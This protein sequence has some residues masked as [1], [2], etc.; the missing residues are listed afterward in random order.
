MPTAT[1]SILP[2]SYRWSPSTLVNDSTIANPTALIPT[3]TTFRLIVKAGTCKADTAF[4]TISINLLPSVIAG[5]DTSIGTG[6]TTPLRSNGA[7]SYVWSPITGLSNAQISN[8]D[9]SPLETTEY[10]VTGSDVNGCTDTDT[11]KVFVKNDLFIPDLFSPDGNG[12]NEAFKIFGAG[13]KEIEF[14]IYNRYGEVIYESKDLDELLRKGWDGSFK[15]TPQTTGTYLWTME[16]KAFDG[17]ELK[18]RG[19]KTGTVVLKR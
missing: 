18:Y 8:P 11:L 6:E 13:I 17:T 5:R 12:T 3:D 1:G 15:G 4:I 7:L 14:K 16:G 2:Y 9:A 19:K 10:I